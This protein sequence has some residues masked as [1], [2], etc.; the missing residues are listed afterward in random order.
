VATQWL[1]VGQLSARMMSA[2]GKAVVVKCRPS[3]VER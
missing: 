1:A 2:D 3:S